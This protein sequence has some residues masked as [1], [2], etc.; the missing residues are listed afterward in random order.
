LQRPWLRFVLGVSLGVLLLGWFLWTTEWSA[1]LEALADVRPGWVLVSVLILLGE[2]AIRAVR[3]RTLLKPVAPQA[4]FSA[5]LAATLIGGA[6]N[7]LLPMRAGDVARPLIAHRRTGL[8][9]TTLVVT[10]VV[11]RVFDLVGMLFVLLLAL[12]TLPTS[13]GPEGV[14]VDNLRRYGLLLGGS[15]MLGLLF[16]SLLARNRAWLAPWVERLVAVLPHAPGTVARRLLVGLMD[17]MAVMAH[18]SQILAAVGASLLLWFNGALAIYVLFQAFGLGLPFGAA[19]FTGVALAL[20]VVLPQAPGFVG[21]FHVAI[22]K[23]MV[24]WG[25]AAAPAK[26][27]AV[28][29]WGVSF[30]PVTLL[31]LAALWREG[32]TL[33]DLLAH[34]KEALARREPPCHNPR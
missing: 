13:H 15:G 25:L 16:L 27:Y 9:V 23:T 33:S 6:V 1:F 29:L 12:A 18:P 24:L 5:L 32:L 21:V 22:E 30:L 2:F 8:P 10:N 11:E 3:W 20:T 17:G 14:L 7:T 19:A 28:V 4:S 34:D 31:G 26:G